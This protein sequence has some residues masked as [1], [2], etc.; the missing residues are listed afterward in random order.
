M[1]SVVGVVPCY[2][3]DAG[4]RHAVASLLTE[5]ERVVVCVNGADPEHSPAALDLVGSGAEV[6]FLTPGSKAKAWACLRQVEADILVFCDADVIIEPGSV[7]KLVDALGAD[8]ELAVAAADERHEP[9][10]T[11]PGRV[12]AVPF[13]L[14]HTGI[15]GPLYAGRRS[16]LPAE[17]AE[18][19]LED[20]WLTAHL[21]DR[22]RRVPGA[23]AWIK[24]PAT[25][26]DL[27]TQRVQTAA[28]RRQLAALGITLSPGPPGLT[29]SVVA[30]TYPLREWPLVAA[31]AAIKA[32]AALRAKLGPVRKRSPAS[33]KRG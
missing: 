16:L 32:A 22:A 17:V 15:A 26:A 4:V 14:S 9:A 10:T 24:S 13:R 28:A 20:A 27:W 5:V 21:G 23:A 8:P 11:I 31:L 3:M 2:E 7:T 19:Y 29:P 1:T 25:W 18:V 30:R 6:V 12:A 33:T